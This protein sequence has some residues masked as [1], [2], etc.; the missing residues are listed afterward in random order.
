MSG[1]SSL[2]SSFGRNL[3]RT[4]AKQYACC[5]AGR[6]IFT[7][8]N[9]IHLHRPRRDPSQ[10]VCLLP[11]TWH[12][13]D[14]S[15]EHANPSSVTSLQNRKNLCNPPLR[16]TISQLNPILVFLKSQ[17]YTGVCPCWSTWLMK[18]WK[19]IGY[20]ATLH[21]QSQ[22]RQ[23]SC[24]TTSND[25]GGLSGPL[26]SMYERSYHM[27]CIALHDDSGPTPVFDQ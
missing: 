7:Q 13:V 4:D 10:V 6:C 25:K 16:D 22:Q 15:R 3:N 1:T 8:V 2:C 14:N 12:C 5:E 19:L 23:E 27:R 9:R 11:Q 24:D 20:S 26:I 17:A 21:E 18:A